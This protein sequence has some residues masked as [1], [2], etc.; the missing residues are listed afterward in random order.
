MEAARTSET[1]VNFYQTTRCYN[2][3]DS[4]LHTHRRENLKS[5]LYKGGLPVGTGEI[6][7]IL[8][9][10][11]LR[12]AG[13]GRQSGSTR[14]VLK[15]SLH[16]IRPFRIR[17][18]GFMLLGRS[19]VTVASLVICRC[20]WFALFGYLC[21][22]ATYNT[23]WRRNSKAHTQSVKISKY[24]CTDSFAVNRVMSHHLSHAEAVTLK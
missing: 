8:R 22:L 15:D 21:P 14:L 20:V 16:S 13:R 2:P 23:A 7:E 19:S 17:M 6:D 9:R 18:S 10:E 5:Y 11:L 12:A 4:N 1:L 24:V 3:E